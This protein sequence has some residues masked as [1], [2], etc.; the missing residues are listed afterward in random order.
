MPEADSDRFERAVALAVRAFR[1]KTRKGTTIPYTTHLFAVTSFVGEYGGDEEQMIA[2]VLHD[3]LEDVRG[4]NPDELERE[5]GPRVRG[6]V[7]G[8]TDTMVHPKPAWRARKETYIA[9]LA[10]K[11]AELK[12]I[13]AADKLHNCMAIRRDYATH[14]EVL[15]SRFSGGR[16]GTLWYYRSVVGALRTGWNHDLATRLAG[17]VRALH[18]DAG[19]P[20]PATWAHLPPNGPAATQVVMCKTGLARHG[21]DLGARLAIVGGELELVDCFDKCE[22]CEVFVL[23]KIDG[24]FFKCRLAQELV[25]AIETLR[26]DES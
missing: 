4:A 14:G 1:G 20:L 9:T 18:L 10:D 26:A 3:Y 21:P 2:A 12:L 16:D 17:E 7:E 15:W 22:Q 5:F 24:A 8:L 13:S 11:P 6:L 25:D 23:A 19:E